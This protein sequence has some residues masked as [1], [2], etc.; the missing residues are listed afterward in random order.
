MD[1]PKLSKTA[2]AKLRRSRVVKHHVTYAYNGLTHNQEEIIVPI[3]NMEHHICTE[4][5]RR[6][7]YVS[8]GFIDWLKYWIWERETTGKFTDLS[9]E[10]DDG[11][12]TN[13]D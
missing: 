5:Q 11:L 4:M 12:I 13:T 3:F 6:G 1:K 10:K 2:R 8:K 7:Q 9:Q